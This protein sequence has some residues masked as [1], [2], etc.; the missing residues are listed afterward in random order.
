MLM[1]TAP[2]VLT[3]PPQKPFKTNGAGKN[4]PQKIAQNIPG[5]SSYFLESLKNAP[6]KLD[7]KNE[8]VSTHPQA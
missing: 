8:I 7:A 5:T 4:D 2:F 1:F 3:E 6:P